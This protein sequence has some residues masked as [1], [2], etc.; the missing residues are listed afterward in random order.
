MHSPS[1]A[2]KDRTSRSTQSLFR[3]PFSKCAQSLKGYVGST[4][5]SLVE[6]VELA[7]EELV[8]REHVDGGLLENSLHLVIAAYLALV[9]G[10]LQVVRFDMLPQLLD[11]LGT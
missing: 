8:H 2:A 6:R 1:V 7:A 4:A 11:D 10:L 5:G 9:G 3:L